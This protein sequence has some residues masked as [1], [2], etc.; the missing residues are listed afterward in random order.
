MIWGEEG[1]LMGEIRQGDHRDELIVDPTT[2]VEK[3][4]KVPLV[5]G[6]LM[7]LGGW[8]YLMMLDYQ[9]VRGEEDA[10]WSLLVRGFGLFVIG[11]PLWKL[12]DVNY[13]VDLVQGTVKFYCRLGFWRF[14]RFVCDFSGIESLAIDKKSTTETV[15]ET[16]QNLFYTQTRTHTRTRITVFGLVLVLKNGRRLRVLDR[17]YADLSGLERHASKL[18]EQMKVPLVRLEPTF[19]DSELGRCIKFFVGLVILWNVLPPILMMVDVST[20]GSKRREE[21]RVVPTPRAAVVAESLPSLDTYIQ[22]LSRDGREDMAAAL[23]TIIEVKAPPE[24]WAVIVDMEKPT[25][26]QSLYRVLTGALDAVDSVARRMKL[27]E[28][29]SAANKAEAAK[30]LAGWEQHV[31]L[32]M[33]LAFKPD[34]ETLPIMTRNIELGLRRIARVKPWRD[35]IELTLSVIPNAEKVTVTKTPTGM[36]V[37]VPARTPIGPAQLGLEL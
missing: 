23:S 17:K 8:F 15:R 22:A 9:V 37:A 32:H 5:L 33:D 19:W 31:T 11:I 4:L 34:V 20:R 30:T 13:R 28:R 29:P 14:T 18:A 25:Q 10:A 12:L 24:M 36:V 7:M 27:P 16:R 21:T 26:D 1:S 6:I 3:L 2:T 35:P